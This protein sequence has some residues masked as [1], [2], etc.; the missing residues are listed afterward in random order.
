MPTLSPIAKIR[1]VS[2]GAFMSGLVATDLFLKFF[3]SSWPLFMYL[4]VGG[5]GAWRAESLHRR[6]SGDGRGSRFVRGMSIGLAGISALGFVVLTALPVDWGSKCSWRYCS[7]ALG[8]GLFDSPFPVGT[9]TCRGWSVCVNEYSYSASE[10]Q[11]MLGRIE[12]QGC[13]EP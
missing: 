3:C 1:L 9:P 6:F 8:P 7:R 5:F 13:P 11:R 12:K 4:A 10:Y 2:A